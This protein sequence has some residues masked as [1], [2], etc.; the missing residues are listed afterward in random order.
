MGVDQGK[1]GYVSVCEW[2][3]PSFDRDINS[4]AIG[5]L[6]WFGRFGEE[7]WGV[8]DELMREWQV[9]ACVVD[10][11]PNINEARRFARRFWGYVW[12]T[13][14]RKGQTAREMAIV[15]EDNA[16]IAQVDRANWL[17]CTL[18]RF[19]T[20]PPRIQLPRDISLEYREHL[21]NVVRTYEKDD[22]GNPQLTYVSTGPDHY[23]HSLVY[24]E[25]GLP[26][27]AAM[28]QN[29]DISKFL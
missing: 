13:R 21:K 22:F 27:A 26:L 19:K 28:T 14:Y 9:L 29:Q 25:L 5:K 16:P 7:Q 23:T 8:L 15:E 10:A 20:Q 2:F 11:D 24:A 3:L 17:S 4:V 18:G 1:T 6:I 12:L